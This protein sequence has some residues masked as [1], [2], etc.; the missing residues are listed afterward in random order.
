[1][2]AQAAPRKSAEASFGEEKAVA[3]YRTPK[4]AACGVAKMREKKS[5]RDAGATTAK[6]GDCRR[7]VISYRA[8]SGTRTARNLRTAW[9]ISFAV[10]PPKPRMNPWRAFLPR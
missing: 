5:R 7:F 2:E 8:R 1:M 3:S 4:D 6:A 10:V 9:G